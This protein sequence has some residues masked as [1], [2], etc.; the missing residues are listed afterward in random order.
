MKCHPRGAVSLFAFWFLFFL[1]FVLLLFVHLSCV[2]VRLPAWLAGYLSDC[3]LS[4]Y[5]S[6]GWSLSR[7]LSLSLV[8]VDLRWKTSL[9]LQ[10]IHSPKLVEERLANSSKMQLAC[11][12]SDSLNFESGHCGTLPPQILP[13][14][15]RLRRGH[16]FW[17]SC[18]VPFRGILIEN[19]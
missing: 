3:L 17:L 16:C 10:T 5:P 4:A 15:Q 7:R 14:R 13:A 12:P 11:F 6:V 18:S 2:F 19:H 1:L 9:D 8:L